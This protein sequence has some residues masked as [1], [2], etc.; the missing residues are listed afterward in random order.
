MKP[1]HPILVHFP[2]ALLPLSVTADIVGHFAALGSLRDTGWWTLLAAALGGLATVAAGLYDMRR[3]P[4]SEAAHARVHRHMRF[5]LTL[6]AALIGLALWRGYL[7]LHELPLPM[8][9]LDASVLATALAAFQGWLGGELV[10]RDGVFVQ[11]PPAGPDAV[12]SDRPAAQKKTKKPSQ[13][14]SIGHAH[15][16]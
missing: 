15:H 8:L 9:Y 10:Y 2:L 4:L 16:H 5:G 14:K 11:V 3:A 1:V 12:S 6:L 13:G 7:Q